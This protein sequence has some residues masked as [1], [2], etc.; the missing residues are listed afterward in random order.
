MHKM[1]DSAEQ[2]EIVWPLQREREKYNTTE[3]DHITFT[4][5]RIRPSVFLALLALCII[6]AMTE[7][8]SRYHT[9]TS[10]ILHRNECPL[11]LVEGHCE[12]NPI[13]DPIFFQISFSSKKQT[14]RHLFNLLP[15]NCVV[16]FP[17]F[18]PIQLIINTSCN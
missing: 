10:I 16:A 5:P 8:R 6:V 12:T 3:T 2:A 15:E 13:P 4:K 11:R 1:K 17:S 14:S 7:L 18:R 9:L